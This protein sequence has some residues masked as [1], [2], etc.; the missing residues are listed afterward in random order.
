MEYRI[1]EGTLVL[2]GQWSDRSYNALLPALSEVPGFNIVISRDE[3][4]YGTEFDDYMAV[5]MK[6][7]CTTLKG[8]VLEHEEA[9]VLAERPARFLEFSWKNENTQIFQS[10]LVINDQPCILSL[11]STSPGS[12]PD[13]VRA[14][15]KEAFLGFTFA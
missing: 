11:T 7:F 5:Q 1:N 8:F 9:L 2:P 6:K 13:E 15:V 14:Q 3:L 10:V 4:P 12:Y